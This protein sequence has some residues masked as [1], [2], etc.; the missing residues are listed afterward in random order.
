[1]IAAVKPV[2]INPKITND[3]DDL[4]LFANININN[5][6]INDPNNEDNIITHGLFNK[7]VNPNVANKKTIIATPKLAIDVTPKTD[8]SAN[9][10]LNNSCIRNPAVGNERPTRTAVT[11]FGKRKLKTKF[12]VIS[13]VDVKISFKEITT[14]PIVKLNKNSSIPKKQ[15][16]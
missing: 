6:A 16:R 10:F 4:T 7:V 1:M 2:N 15:S 12:F 9:G 11:L 3:A 5:N 8:G 13:S 14:F